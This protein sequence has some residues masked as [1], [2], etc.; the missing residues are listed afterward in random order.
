DAAAAGEKL[1]D[2][3]E[4]QEKDI[5][6]LKERLTMTADETAAAY[7]E[8]IKKLS[9]DAD[10]N[11]KKAAGFEGSL[12]EA[13]KEI[14]RLKEASVSE[15][16][17]ADEFN[18]KLKELGDII[19]KQKKD[20]SE[21]M[22]YIKN[23]ELEFHKILKKKDEDISVLKA[24]LELGLEALD[25]KSAAPNDKRLAELQRINEEIGRKSAQRE[26]MLRE[27]I[28][29]KEKEAAEYRNQIRAAESSQPSDH[30]A[31][32]PEL[33]DEIKS[34]TAEALRLKSEMER[35]RKYYERLESIIKKQDEKISQLQKKDGGG[36]II[37]KHDIVP[38]D[39]G[40]IKF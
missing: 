37:K 5:K 33:E 21:K 40:D 9:A 2:L 32:P 4:K 26:A 11:R 19:E 35:A 17:Q 25:G 20:I 39:D 7:D 3:T 38:D 30:P 14:A 36:S 15:N 27:E 10:E 28:E 23:K 24:Q 12:R 8:K 16:R 1:S 13:E 22:E 31:V 34:R 18:E 6:D 29:R